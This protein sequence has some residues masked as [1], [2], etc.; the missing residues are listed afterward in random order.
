MYSHL[1]ADTPGRANVCILTAGVG[2]VSYPIAMYVS[3][4]VWQRHNKVSKK[5]GEQGE[6]FN[7]DA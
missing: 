4:G 1:N 3:L 7:T 2:I 5:T 6:F